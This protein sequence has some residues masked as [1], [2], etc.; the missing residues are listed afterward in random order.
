MYIQPYPHYSNILKQFKPK[1]P[2]NNPT[3]HTSPLHNP[4]NSY[5]SQHKL[6]RLGPVDNRLSPDKLHH[7][8]QKKQKKL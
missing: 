6:D 3:Y 7:F 8:V 4:N 2:K 5:M 1:I